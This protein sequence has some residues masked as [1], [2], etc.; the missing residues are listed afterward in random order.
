[1]AGLITIPNRDMNGIADLNNNFEYLDGLAKQAMNQANNHGQFKDWSTDGIV[2]HNGFSLENDSGYRYWQLPNGWKLV[3]I[4][5]ISKLSTDNFHG[6]DWFTLPDIVKPN[7]YQIQET[8]AGGYYT[9]QSS[10]TTI[11]LNPTNGNAVEHGGWIHS[12]HT[13]YFSN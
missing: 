4:I 1:M 13:M 9:N 2:T 10:P 6:G 7:S 11:S 5:I 8:V 3:E 12:L